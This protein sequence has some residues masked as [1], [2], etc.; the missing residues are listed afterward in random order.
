MYN[1][2]DTWMA[3]YLGQWEGQKEKIGVLTF[4]YQNAY[5]KGHRPDDSTQP[6]VLMTNDYETLLEIVLEETLWVWRSFSSLKI[7]ISDEDVIV[8][9]T[10]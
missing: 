1:T 4:N 9:A 2:F 5:Q 6:Q 7:A 3:V 8:L 10:L